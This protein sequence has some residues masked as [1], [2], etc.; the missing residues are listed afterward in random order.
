MPT[1]YKKIGGAV[2]GVWDQNAVTKD[3]HII[4]RLNKIM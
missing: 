3:F 1:K 2:I 4:N